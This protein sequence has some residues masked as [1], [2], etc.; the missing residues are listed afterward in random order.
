M[1]CKVFLGMQTHG[2]THKKSPAHQ[3]GLDHSN[4]LNLTLAGCPMQSP[5]PFQFNN[6]KFNSVIYFYNMSKFAAI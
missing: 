2:M 1:Q 6:A 5:I 3:A 4:R